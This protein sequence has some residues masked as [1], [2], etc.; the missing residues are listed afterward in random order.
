MAEPPVAEQQRRLEA[1]LRERDGL[2]G[3]ILQKFQHHLQLYSLL[4]PTAAVVVTA[5]VGRV[6]WDVVLLIP[7]VT[8]GFAFRYLWEEQ[9][10]YSIGNYLKTQESQKLPALIGTT[11]GKVASPDAPRESDQYWVAWEHYFHE[12]FP[13]G[14][15]RMPFYRAASLLAFVGTPFGP[16][17]VFALLSIWRELFGQPAGLRS[18]LPLWAHVVVLLAYGILGGLLAM[19]LRKVGGPAQQRR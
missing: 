4:T 11:G 8:T 10:I 14:I 1:V 13:P 12:D 16:A 17:V 6:T 19:Q 2:R 18:I 9:V 5:L 7:I 15:R 3:E